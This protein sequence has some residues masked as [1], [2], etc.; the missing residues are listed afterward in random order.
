MKKWPMV[1]IN[2][3]KIT[4]GT[5]FVDFVAGGHRKTQIC[6][7][8]GS[9]NAPRKL[10]KAPSMTLQWSHRKYCAGSVRKHLTSDPSVIKD[11]I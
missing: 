6:G 11:V 7:G 9:A 1:S 8:E 4:V 2:Y 10:L 3:S 5:A